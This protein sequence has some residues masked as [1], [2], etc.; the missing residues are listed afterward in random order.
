MLAGHCCE[1][2]LLRD[3]DYICQG[4]SPR[5][6]VCQTITQG[7]LVIRRGW[8]WLRSARTPSLR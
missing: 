2:I 5:R 7:K 1:P 4:S 3:K 8:D 6:W